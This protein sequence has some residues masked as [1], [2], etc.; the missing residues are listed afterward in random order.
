MDAVDFAYERLGRFV[1]AS[2]DKLAW[3]HGSYPCIKSDPNAKPGIG[4]FG[5]GGDK[6]NLIY[7]TEQRSLLIANVSPALSEGSEHVELMS[8]PQALERFGGVRML[9][10]E[11][12]FNPPAGR[13][14]LFSM[15]KAN[16]PATN[17]VV[18]VSDRLV[19]HSNPK[20]VV[21]TNN[22][23]IREAYQALLEYCDPGTSH[24][25]MRTK[26]KQARVLV[27]AKLAGRTMS[28]HETAEY[29]KIAGSP[30]VRAIGMLL[31]HQSI[32]AF[33]DFLWYQINKEKQS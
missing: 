8:C 20:S 24:S 14:M 25:V 6:S 16:M 11:I 26:A 12:R 15:S 4:R 7:I 28:A 1:R 19:S 29:Q 21:V 32:Q 13:F 2:A 3:L 22:A 23:A 31:R 17:L 10:D 27:E 30:L 33:E 9:A 5:T 18:N